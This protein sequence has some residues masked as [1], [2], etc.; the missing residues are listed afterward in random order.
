MRFIPL[1]FIPL[2]ASLLGCSEKPPTQ[3]GTQ[4]VETGLSEVKEKEK[5]AARAKKEAE[6]AEVE[7]K[8]KRKEA[9]IRQK[10]AQ[11]AKEKADL[12]KQRQEEVLG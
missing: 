7:A 6:L 12:T 8:L 5:A 4:T 2:L 3:G 1:G 11:L 9:E 10:E